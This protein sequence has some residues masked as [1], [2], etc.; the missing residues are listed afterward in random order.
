MAT[1]AQYTLDQGEQGSAVLRLAGPYLLSTVG[2]VDR[3][4]RKLDAQIAEVDLS[5]VTEI[6]TVV[7]MLNQIIAEWA[8][9]DVDDLGALLNEALEAD[10]VLADRLL[11]SRNKTWAGWIDERL[12]SPGTIFMAVGA[13]HLAGDRSVQDYLAERGISITRVQ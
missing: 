6:D 10:P 5:D 9:G 13:G 11:Y 4:L 3:G 1:E 2:G 8:E 12:D 7:P